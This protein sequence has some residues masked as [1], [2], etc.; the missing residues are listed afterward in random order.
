MEINHE[1][2]RDILYIIYNQTRLS[3]ER[4]FVARM[5]GLNVNI[6]A[7]LRA[8]YLA[9]ELRTINALISYI[10]TN[11]DMCCMPSREEDQI[12]WLNDEEINKE[13]VFKI[14]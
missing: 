2:E 9:R 4:M 8:K 10:R 5:H 7:R 14:K 12:S 1:E 11:W 3:E 6:P 13:P